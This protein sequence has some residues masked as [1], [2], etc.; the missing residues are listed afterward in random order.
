MINV[1]LD[2]DRARPYNQLMPEKTKTTDNPQKAVQAFGDEP[3]QP[4]GVLLRKIAKA[5]DS[6]T[7]ED[8]VKKWAAAFKAK[9]GLD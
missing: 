6:G 4:S 2:G 7:A 1:R 9:Y 5:V 8:I 3:M